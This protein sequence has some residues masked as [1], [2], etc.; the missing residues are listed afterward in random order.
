MECFVFA[1]SNLCLGKK[2]APELVNC[3]HKLCI[4]VNR[5]M[6]QLTGMMVFSR[7]LI[8]PG[9]EIAAEA[10]FTCFMGL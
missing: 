10:F 3:S 9:V 4:V 6:V 8:L 2:I 5:A 1:Y 7:L